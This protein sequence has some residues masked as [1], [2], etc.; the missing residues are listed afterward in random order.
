MQSNDPTAYRDASET[1]IIANLL[2]LKGRRVLELG[3]GAAWMTRLL[4]ERFEPESIVATEVDRIQHEKNLAL[5]EIPSLVSFRIGGA[6]SIDAPDTSVDAV[7]MFK[8][9]HHVPRDLMD[10][11]LREIHRVLVP[12]GRA[13]FSE[14]VYW[15]E[16][17]QIMRLI[18]DEKEVREAAFQALARS[19]DD[20]LFALEAEIFF[21]SPGTFESWEQFEQRFLKVT[22]T[23]LSIDA[24]CYARI[25]NAF[26]AHMTPTGAHFLKPHRVDLLRKSS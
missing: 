18:H 17:N 25:R 21:Q 7:F 10:Q 8:S 5:A 26:M 2:D 9:L 16:F 1:E 6:E 13:Y 23:E 11:A 24:D 12:A 4:A 19:V 15:G 22:H 14:P 3:C 20:G